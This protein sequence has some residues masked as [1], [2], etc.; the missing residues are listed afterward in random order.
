MTKKVMPYGVLS[1]AWARVNIH[2]ECEGM[3]GVSVFR[4]CC[5]K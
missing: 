4:G 5:N 3:G 2:S 1:R